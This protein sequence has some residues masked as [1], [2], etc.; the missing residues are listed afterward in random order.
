M[1]SGFSQRA[2]PVLKQWA[3]PFVSVWTRHGR[4]GAV[5]VAAR[6]RRPE[7]RA[8]RWVIDGLPTPAG[9]AV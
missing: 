2:G 6:S 7:I 1:R 9:S 5:G 4:S 8:Y 3:G